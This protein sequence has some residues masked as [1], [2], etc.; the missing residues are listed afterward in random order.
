MKLQQIALVTA[1]FVG[2]EAAATCYVTSASYNAAELKIDKI[3]PNVQRRV[4]PVTA[5]QDQ[6]T[7]EMRVMV[8]GQWH[9]LRG[10][11]RGPKNSSI[12]A[13]CARAQNTG[14]TRLLQSLGSSDISVRNEMIC[15]D[16]PRVANTRLV[17]VGDVIALSDVSPDPDKPM[18]F[19]DGQFEARYFLETVP[20][21]GGGFVQNRG[22]IKR[23]KKDEWVVV[24]KWEN[25]RSR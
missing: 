17:R 10:E 12:D 7:V 1:L 14:Q 22:V 23:L 15:Q 6:C 20:M 3:D 16:G 4:V 18:S 19:P 11:A 24:D 13:L 2:G 21:N 8:Q 25:A 5:E 9:L